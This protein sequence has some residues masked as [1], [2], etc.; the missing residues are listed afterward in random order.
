MKCT[1]APSRAGGDRLVGALAARPQFE[2]AAEDGLAETRLALG[3]VGGVGDEDPED[4][5]GTAGG[6]RRHV[7]SGGTTPLRNAKQP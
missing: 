1:S 6:H 2:G 3:P 7:A 5:D 4:D